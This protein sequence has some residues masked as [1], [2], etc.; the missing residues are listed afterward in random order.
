MKSILPSKGKGG[1][2]ATPHLCIDP[3]VIVCHAVITALQEIISRGIDP[4]SPGVLTI[5]KIY[6]DGGATNVIPDTVYLEGTLRA[7]DEKWRMIPLI[8]KSKNLVEK[9]CQASGALQT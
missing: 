5:G 7:M 2:A 4:L 9:I 3:I 1:H 6:S 8:T